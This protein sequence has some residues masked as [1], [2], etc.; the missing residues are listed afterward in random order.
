MK[1]FRKAEDD[2]HDSG[3]DAVTDELRAKVDRSGMPDEARHIAMKELDLLCRMSPSTS[4]YTI[5]LSYI[6]YLVSLPWNKKTE[7]IL[8][9][10]RAEKILN[11]NHYGLENIK[12]R[13]LEY[14]AVKKLKRD[15]EPMVLLVD[16]EAVALKNLAHILSKDKYTIVT[17]SS[18]VE[19]FEKLSRA[20]FDVVLTDF[21]M[22]KVDG[23][24]VLAGIKSRSPHTEVIMITGYATI[25]TAVEAMK[26]GAFHYIPKP[27]NIDEVRAVVRQALDKRM[28]RK[29]TKGS[30]LCFSG[31]PGTGKTSLGRSIALA[32][33]RT[34]S[35]ISVGGIKDE[36][37][38]RG[39]RRTYAG[40]MP[41]RIIEEIRRMGSSNPLIILDEL[42]KVGSD[43]K[44]DPSAAL[45]EVLDPEQNH[46]FTDHYV[47]L[48][49]D[50]SDV[51]FIITANVADNIIDALRDRMEVIHFSGYTEAEKVQIASRFLVPR[52]VMETGLSAAPP[53]FSEEGLYKIV[54]DYTREAG[55]RNL[56]REIASICRKIARDLVQHEDH[57]SSLMVDAAV[58]EK[59]L[60]PRKYYFE[61]AE[62]ED[63]IGVATGLVWTDVGGDII[64]IE[65]VMMRGKRELTLTGSLGDVMRESAHTAL[66]FIRSNAG[67]FG[68][69]EDF[70]EDHDVHIHIPAGAIPKDGPY[71]GLTMAIALL[72]LLTGRAARRDVALSGELTLSGRVLPVG[73]IKEKVLAAKRAGVK[74]VVL[75]RRNENDIDSLPQDIR[76]G[77]EVCFTEKIEDIV[78]LVLKK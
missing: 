37:E 47:D 3:P 53:L 65:A 30:V 11:E 4:E 55:I 21:R 61:V 38:I 49:F 1:F 2:Q 32:L 51:L 27:F 26:K 69:S 12:D 62:E 13:V 7:D 8:D 57:V 64:F 6:E 39:H 23:M 43:F 67:R 73:G 70:F 59:S 14:L 45:L 41:G 72:S 66:S 58:I 35:R 46:H 74:T 9:I 16:D 71:A 54:R 63:R 25:D 19:A 68:I 36:A 18:G 48:P 28:Y 20:E 56:N 31:P 24:E 52:Q 17:A 77:L 44:G 42:D 50:L 78:E 29:D 76:E 75:P 33:G 15:R 40:A 34:F 60:G 5:S 10:D 22:E